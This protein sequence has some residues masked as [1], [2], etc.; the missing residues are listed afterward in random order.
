MG[1][2]G[3]HKCGGKGLTCNRSFELTSAHNHYQDENLVEAKCFQSKSKL[4]TA[5]NFRKNV[6]EK[7]NKSLHDS[8]SMFRLEFNMIL[9]LAFVP[10]NDVGVALDDVRFMPSIYF[11]TRTCQERTK[12]CTSFDDNVDLFEHELLAGTNSHDSSLIFGGS[13]YPD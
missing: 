11:S 9:A 1:R 5:K 8:N 3:K 13:Q 6:Y 12:R 2:N 10:V 4:S 7:G